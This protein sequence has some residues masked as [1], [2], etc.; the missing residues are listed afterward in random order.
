MICSSCP[1]C[2]CCCSVRGGDSSVGRANGRRNTDASWIQSSVRRGMYFSHSQLTYTVSR[3]ANSLAVSV[4]LP[5]AIARINICAHVKKSKL[6]QPYHYLNTQKYC[7]RWQEW[8]ALLL[9]L[10]RLKPILNWANVCSPNI[11]R[12][13]R[14]TMI[15][16]L[17][18][19]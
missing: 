8:V 18:D 4:Q 16:F 1:C 10:L 12:T 14:R 6:W 19:F 7:T 17:I 11:L 13:V 9:R 5:C 2:C 3:S 15:R